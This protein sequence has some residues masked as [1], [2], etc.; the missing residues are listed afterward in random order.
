[1]ATAI[2][3]HACV[4]GHHHFTANHARQCLLHP[5][6]ATTHLATRFRTSL[7]ASPHEPE[8]RGLNLLRL[9]VANRIAEFHT[10]L[11]TI[12]PQVCAPALLSFLVPPALTG[13]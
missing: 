11:E 13:L 1:M 6:A 4:P 12:S 10:E 3:T 9:L 7:P 2:L 8:L 5:V